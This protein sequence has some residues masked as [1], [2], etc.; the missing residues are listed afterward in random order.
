MTEPIDVVR[1]FCD[2]WG[3]PEQITGALD[4]LADDCVYHNIPMDPIVGIEAIRAFVEGFV[5]GVDRAAWEVRAIA[6]SG[7]TVLTERVDS[8]LYP[9]HRIDLPVMGAFEVGAD[10]RITAWRDYFDLNQFMA[11]MG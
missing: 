6:A 8:F 1:Q 5:A 7:S 10:G 9:D 3:T 4:R 11:Q 2:S